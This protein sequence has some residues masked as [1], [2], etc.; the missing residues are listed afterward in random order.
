MKAL[1]ALK[2]LN[3]LFAL[4][5]AVYAA[6]EFG[7]RAYFFMY[8]YNSFPYQTCKSNNESTEADNEIISKKNDE[9][10]SA[11]A[12]FTKY[13][14]ETSQHNSKIAS[15]NQALQNP[16]LT[17]EEREQL[18][19]ENET[20]A[21]DASISSTLAQGARDLLNEKPKELKPTKDCFNDI[22]DQNALVFAWFFLAPISSATV[23]AIW[24]IASREINRYFKP[25]NQS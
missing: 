8:N 6:L 13:N 18:Q 2:A 14:D 20:E 11:K 7:N 4:C 3:G 21:T 15:N 25:N 17:D 22:K 10:S 24:L 23:L 5:L 19:F 12:D 16:N 1:K 9:I